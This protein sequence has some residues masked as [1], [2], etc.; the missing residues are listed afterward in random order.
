V[1]DGGESVADLVATYE[2]SDQFHIRYTDQSALGRS[3]AANRALELATGEFCN[4]LDDDDWWLPQHLSGLVDALLDD[5]TV[6]GAYSDTQALLPNGDNAP[7]QFDADYDP[8]KLVRE[9]FLPL[10]SVLFRR[11]IVDQGARFD[12]S[13]DVYE[14]WSFWLAV[15][16]IGR[17]KRISSRT[18]IYS[19]DYSGVGISSEQSFQEAY[20]TFLEVEWPKFS[21][22]Q[23][24]SMHYSALA[25]AASQQVVETK[26]TQI[27]NLE[28]EVGVLGEAL[29]ESQ[30]V[31]ETKSQEIMDLEREVGV[32]GE[33]LAE[34]QQVVE[35]KSQEIMDLEREVGV[36]GEALAESQQVVET[37]S[38]EIMGLERE[39]AVLDEHLHNLQRQKS[40]TE[41]L[42]KELEL[43]KSLMESKNREL[44]LQNLDLQDKVSVL[45]N[46]K[47]QLH[48]VTAELDA[49]IASLQAD[50]AN[51]QFEIEQIKLAGRYRV[52]SLSAVRNI[53]A[54]LRRKLGTTLRLLR[55]GHARVLLDRVRFNK[56]LF[57]RRIAKRKTVLPEVP[58]QVETTLE[59]EPSQP[60]DSILPKA[61]YPGDLS[62]GVTILATRHTRFV[63]ELIADN[64]CEIFEAARLEPVDT[65]VIL[66]EPSEYTDQL[67]IV[68]CPQMFDNLPLYYIA[69]QMEQSVDSR[70]FTDE[71]IAR[72]NRAQFI[73]DY[74]LRNVAYLLEQ[75]ISDFASTFY[76]PISNASSSVS[77][78]NE[79][80][81]AVEYDVAFYGDPNSDR[82]IRLLNELKKH[83]KVLVIS[84]V[85][86]EALFHEL[87]KA[88]LVVNIHYYEGALLET[89]R[90]YE[91]V[92][93]GY[94]VVSESSVDIDEHSA[95]DGF[96][97]F[98]PIGDAQA[99][100]QAVK[101]S[102]EA[103]ESGD[104]PLRIPLINDDL[105]N[106]RYHL[107]RA[108]F[109][110]DLIPEIPAALFSYSASKA[111]SRPTLGLSLPETP[112][113]RNRFRARFPEAP[114][115]SGIRHVE[116]WRGAALSYKYLT[117]WALVAGFDSI[118]IREDDAFFAEGDESKWDSAKEVF[119][120]GDYDLLCG[121]IA[122][123]S[124]EAKVLDAFEEEGQ[125]YIVIDKMV[126]MVCNIYSKSTIQ[127][128]AN[129][130]PAAGDMYTNTIDR[131]LEKVPLKVLVPIPFLAR[132]DAVQTSTLWG[133][134]NDT[135]DPMIEK[136]EQR[137]LDMYAAH[138]ARNS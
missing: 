34:S 94:R 32:L 50:K 107:A 102:L 95:L 90:L 138:C 46:E 69:Y 123:L 2:A 131:Y 86:G 129:W 40:D 37:K 3:V 114:V 4:F 23:R 12:P 108:L 21:L 38:Q 78:A 71:Y 115:F 55:H 88:K 93:R 85:F 6:L 59:P 130:D 76:V 63:A 97:Q 106:H 8:A 112:V 136:S 73:F 111:E 15:A 16:R 20:K 80:V 42:V 120:S 68:V 118:E 126:S 92:S 30:Q 56:E 25:L 117:N 64:L 101:F 7:K 98:S 43:E 1:N 87:D 58:S 89:T 36:L 110:K 116:G 29:A 91:S 133:F 83:F 65:K 14:D 82:R 53:I 19:S 74:S 41:L 124:Y 137:L 77:R 49:R 39:V 26:S 31:V 79:R 67:H 70:W 104:T 51:L 99:L 84:E 66:E 122:D 100:V 28:G 60:S 135:Y 54:L 9:N 119:F 125:K 113:R 81:D 5:D 27:M 52:I 121:L 10:H 45:C 75:G 105:A 48:E 18:A 127:L 17:L 132:H 11:Q 44:E 57:M 134:V 24:Q 35:T 103:I 61:I 109:C 22:E 72:L 128:L 47:S 33:A 62:A 13:L 96:V